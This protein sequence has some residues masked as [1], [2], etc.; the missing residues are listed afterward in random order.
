M[1]LGQLNVTAFN[2]LLVVNLLLI[3][4]LVSF[5]IRIGLALVICILLHLVV[6]STWFFFIHELPLHLLLL[7]LQEL[8]LVLVNLFVHLL[9]LLK[10]C[11]SLCLHRA[12]LDSRVHD[13]LALTF[14]LFRWNFVDDLLWVFTLN[15][16]LMLG[17]ELVFV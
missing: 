9:L 13:V 1:F 15:Q 7:S 12:L 14:F 16:L 11:L 10:G 2:V 6:L 4:K 17:I 8:L 5:F 3:G